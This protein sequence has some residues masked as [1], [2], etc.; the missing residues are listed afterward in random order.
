MAKNKYMSELSVDE[1]I[2]GLNFFVPEIQREYVWGY[3]EREIL[4]VFIQDLIEGK[5]SEKNT[6]GLKE[7]IA[8]LSALG[9]FEEIKELVDSRENIKPMNIGFLYSYEPNYRMEHFPE[10]DYNKDVYLIDGQQ[11]LTT[12]FILLFYLAI[13]EN[14]KNEFCDMFRFNSAL[15]SVAFDYRVRNLTHNFFIDLINNID[16]LDEVVNIQES[17]WFLLEYSKDPTVIAVFKSAR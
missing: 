7:K 4:D 17:T 9:K 13:K 10:S 5:N 11:R 8:E 3:N 6:S 14:R 12:L 1:L 2:E 16:K 15:E